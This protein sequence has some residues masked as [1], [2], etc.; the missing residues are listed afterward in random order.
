MGGA[1]GGGGGGPVDPVGRAARAQSVAIDAVGGGKLGPLRAA[2]A[3]ARRVGPVG[4]HTVGG[5]E[6]LPS[7]S[8]GRATAV[9]VHAEGGAGAAQRV[10]TTTA[11]EGRVCALRGAEADDRPAAA[12]GA[13]RGVADGGQGPG[14][15]EL[16][17][18]PAGGQ[19]GHGAWGGR[20]GLQQHYSIYNTT[21]QYYRTQ[22]NTTGQ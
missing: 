6:A 18:P 13:Q 20:P 8:G 22:D 21:G 3:A 4:V 10:S 17:A 5:V 15:L 19:G 9:A 7:Q 14:H 11:Q 1:G 16:G 2:A 12:L